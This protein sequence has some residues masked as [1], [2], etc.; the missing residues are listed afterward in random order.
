MRTGTLF[1]LGL[2][3]A[4]AAARGAITVGPG[5]AIGTDLR[6]TTW[7]E[8]FQD[9]EFGQVRSL[10][11][12]GDGHSFG[13]GLEDGRD[14]VAFYAAFEPA[15]VYLRV[16][17][18]D[19]A[20]GAENGSVD[21]YVAIDFKT[22]G[23]EWLPDNLGPSG[24]RTDHPWEFVVC[25][26]N[27]T[28]GFVKNPDW[29]VVPEAFIGYNGGGYFRSDLDSVEFGI[30]RQTLVDAGW[31][32]QPG[33]IRFQPF[34]AR[35]NILNANGEPAADWIG[36]LEGGYLKDQI[37][38]DAGTSRAKY[39]VIAHANQSVNKAEYTKDHIYF[40][41]DAGGGNLL[42]GGFVRLMDSAEMFGVPVNLHISGSLL[43]SF[44]W[45]RQ[46]P[47]E[48]RY[49]YPLRDGPTFLRR[50]R[51]FVEE[52]PGALIGGTF[53]EHIMPYFEGEANRR[54]IAQRSELMQHVFGV[55]EQDMGV[56]HVPERVIRADV[57]ARNVSA[58]GPLTGMTFAD[59][60][61]SGYEATYLD[62]VTHLHWWFYPNEQDGWTDD[63]H[64]SAWA[65]WMGCQDEPYHHKAHKINGV[66]CFMIND[67]E[68][69]AKFGN[70]DDGMMLDTRVTLHQKAMSPD[71]SQL[72]LVFDDW[73]AYAGK[74]FASSEPNNNPDQFHRTMRWAANRQWI[75]F[76]TLKQ[77]LDWAK[78]DPSWVVDHGTVS[79]K[80]SQTYEWLKRASEHSYDNWYYGGPLEESFFDRVPAVHN[81]WAPDGMKKYGDM[82]T[83]GTL[84]RDT[85]DR[86]QSISS[87]NLRRLAEF[88]YSAMI[89]ETAWHDE[90]ANPDQ[91][92]S[93]N[94]QTTFDRNDSCTTSYEDTTYDPISGW[95][96]AL[97]G[98]IRDVG[99]LKEVDDW[100]Q[101]V[102]SGQQGQATQVI[103]KDLDD[104]RLDDY[105]LCN[106]RVFL[107]FKRWGGRLIQAFVYDAQ[108]NGGDAR[109]VIGST[110][111]NPS[112][113]DE[114]EW[115]YNARCS[116]LKD[117]WSTGLETDRLVDEE[118][119]VSVGSD[120]LTFVSQGGDV[121]KTV[122]LLP[123]R[124]AA[125]VDYALSAAAGTLY[126][127]HGF[128]PGQM[129]LMFNGDAHLLRHQSPLLAGLE[130]ASGGAA[131]VVAGEGAA[132]GNWIPDQTGWNGRDGALIETFETY[133][134][135]PTF[136]LGLAFSLAT[137]V[138]LDGD[139]YTHEQEQV[140]GTDPFDA[141]SY[142][143]ADGVVVDAE[144]AGR[145][146][147]RAATLAG[148]EY[149][150]YYAD[151]LVAPGG[152]VNWRLLENPAT[153]TEGGHT[154]FY[155]A[156][157]QDAR[158][159]YRVGVSGPP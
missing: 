32:G 77:V 127:H 48:E 64:C 13:D 74:S 54:S 134:D 35:N 106:D 27:S 142:F 42:V 91:Y 43:V 87:P 4:G 120:S 101:R 52:G 31:D 67:R 155:D 158:R 110:L 56:M 100:A 84:V 66:Y 70:H 62:E 2:W 63:C 113:E 90:D 6:G 104:G 78:A 82:N 131:F 130:N 39:A 29:Q 143:Q 98:H 1:A 149:R 11:A 116:A 21:V 139:G 15:A 34:T 153:S 49:A 145:I 20:Y 61:A 23:Q 112:G 141:A 10:D 40:D 114:R 7:Y 136:R 118:Y 3:L 94:Y 25:V 47:D 132:I 156:N 128:G 41:Y 79:D 146:G 5:P 53:A 157:P 19:L 71:S 18:H 83:P 80:S 148:R 119:A 99:I 26:A 151:T 76:L 46:D 36:R 24:T 137:A 65:G 86:V 50:V 9:W 85:W 92:Q 121:S 12:I 68:D 129:D 28:N 72:T 59:I 105:A 30:S 125:T 38:G 97:H 58:G 140:A 123:G 135:S 138:D 150:V 51:T 44:L 108:L 159:Y 124:D 103:V 57:G 37:G 55:T 22:G 96:L 109:M 69:Q 60:A 111:A 147:V 33:S 45:A 144:N 17:F 95:A 73:E 115:R 152:S 14:L 102:K 133:S 89:Y 93:R 81:G 126:V 154:I 8:E 107:V 16:D 117:H 122:R 75:E 88:G